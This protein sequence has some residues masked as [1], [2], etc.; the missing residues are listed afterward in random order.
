MAVRV[1]E[2]VLVSVKFSDISLKFSEVPVSTQEGCGRSTG[3]LCSSAPDLGVVL[4]MFM[5]DNK[6]INLGEMLLFDLFP[7]ISLFIYPCH[8]PLVLVPAAPQ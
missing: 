1:P 3:G 7:V 4:I 5:S 8:K 2:G 6:L